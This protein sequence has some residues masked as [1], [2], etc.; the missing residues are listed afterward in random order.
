[1]FGEPLGV[2]FR[3]V[4][5]WVL[6]ITPATPDERDADTRAATHAQRRIEGSLVLQ[7]LSGLNS[8]RQE[9][10]F[11]DITLAVDGDEYPCHKVVLCSFSPYFKAMFS[12]E[13]AESKQ[14]RCV[15]VCACV[16]ACVCV[17]GVCSLCCLRFVF[18]C[19]CLR[20][21]VGKCAHVPLMCGV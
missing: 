4:S 21:C 19:V 11:C 8:L 1:M 18:V 3:R 10:A 13:M 9:R 17:C 6:K 5:S 15:C 16:R 12:G 7:V 20:L 14:V 2:L